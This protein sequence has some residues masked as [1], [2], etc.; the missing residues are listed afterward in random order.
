MFLFGVAFLFGF[1]SALFLCFKFQYEVINDCGTQR[2]CRWIMISIQF[3]KSHIAFSFWQNALKI[4]RLLRLCWH[5]FHESWSEKYKLLKTRQIS[6]LKELGT[7]KT[8]G[9]LLKW[10]ADCL[11]GREDIETLSDTVLLSVPS[12]SQAVQ[13]EPSSGSRW[14]GTAT[15]SVPLCMHREPEEQC[16][17]GAVLPGLGRASPGVQ[18]HLQPVSP[19]P[20]A[21]E[22]LAGRREWPCAAP[23]E[24]WHAVM[25]QHP[26]S[27]SPGAAPSHLSLAAPAEP[28]RDDRHGER[29]GAKY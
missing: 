3:W 13:N 7:L 5:T 26:A 22:L 14:P 11:R 27:P 28:P 12:A 21:Y 16:E 10:W 8:T 19:S 25:L 17:R 1:A 6:I 29:M 15:F 18:T 4:Q 23:A 24:L 2:I 9:E 20:G